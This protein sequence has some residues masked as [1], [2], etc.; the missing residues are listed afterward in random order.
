[1]IRLSAYRRFDWILFTA[2]AVLIAFGLLAIWSVDLSRDPTGLLN[3]K[4]QIAFGSAGILILLLAPLF[5]WRIAKHASRLLYIIGFLLLV[6]VLIAGQ[7]RRGATG[8][9]ALGGITLQP[10]ELAK[11][12]LILALAHYFSNRGFI[13]DWKIAVKSAFLLFLYLVPTILQ[14]DFGGAMVLFVIW[15]GMFLMVR[16]PRKFLV[17]ISIA[18]MIVGALTWTLVL[19]DY[20]RGRVVTFLNPTHDPKGRGYNITQSIVAVGSG[21]LLGRGLGEGSQ[22]QLRFLPEAHTDFIF[23]VLG[24]ELGLIG[25]S[26]ILITFAVLISRLTLL[27]HHLRDN[28]ALFVVAGIELMIGIEALINMGMNLGVLPVTGLPLPLVSYGGSA[29]IATCLAL[30]LTQSIR[31]RS[32]S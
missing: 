27:S 4:K 1:M 17:S 10:I 28:F 19:K 18:L 3:F 9:F 15:L 16:L 31:V 8:W 26:V 29:L 13:P 25:A 22:S 21:G 2:V 30:A 32:A 5:D 24:E 12:T 23:A 7:T 11:I 14:P 6:A 20:Q